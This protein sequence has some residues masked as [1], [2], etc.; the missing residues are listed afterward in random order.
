MN[1]NINEK[2][3]YTEKPKKKFYIIKY[4]KIIK[5]LIM[6]ILISEI[7]FFYSDY[8]DNYSSNKELIIESN[9]YQSF[10]E[11]KKK[12]SDSSR[13]KILKEISIIKHIY[14][15]N[16]Y[17]YKFRKKII[18]ITVSLNNDG[19]YKYI[20]LVSIYSL[21]TNCNKSKTFVIY[22]I[23][24]TPDFN[25]TSLSLFKSIITNFSHN[26]EMIF[27]NMGNNFMNRKNTHYSQATYYRLI[28]SY[29]VNTDRII[30]LDGDTLVFSDLAE[31]YNL[32]FNDIIII[33]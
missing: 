4:S 15:K 31:M 32:N 11:I 22:H 13:R 30:H 1:N 8:I 18:H 25:E 10:N 5:C 16:V 12:E 3:S 14:I 26:V 27:Y 7:G 6:I 29:I 28:I 33:C 9:Q 20:L 19:N 24:C 17:F 23:L 21:L 2:I